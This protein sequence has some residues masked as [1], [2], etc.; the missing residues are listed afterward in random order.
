[1]QHMYVADIGDYGKYGLLRAL[2]PAPY[3]LGIVWYL[4]PNESHLNDGRHISYLSS[5]K[6]FDCDR[7]LFFILKNI[8]SSGER[9][10]S[11]IEKSQILPAGTVYYSEYLTYDGIKANSPTGRLNRALKREQWL[12]KALETV[13]G[14]D[15]VFLDPDNGLE[16]PSVSIHSA[17][18]PKYV[19]YDEI[20]KFMA[21]ADTLIIYHHLSRNGDHA[22]QISNREKKLK[23]LAG[24]SYKVLSIRFQ[25]YSP[26][27]YF[28]ITNQGDMERRVLEFVKSN[29][30]QCFEWMR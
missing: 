9:R 28:I 26:R 27:A 1:M 30:N 23:E 22:A 16:T 29:W 4:V 20:K 19:Y 8:I 12:D 10:I 15:A 13:S 7:D 11:Q 3:R 2:F 5:L 6:Y 21:I 24:D 25:P 14:C 18:A 17:K